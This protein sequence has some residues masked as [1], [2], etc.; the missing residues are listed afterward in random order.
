MSNHF[1]QQ[2]NQGHVSCANCVYSQKAER[3]K[4]WQ[5]RRYPPVL[6]SNS[7]MLGWKFPPVS[8]DYWCGEFV[9]FEDHN[10]AD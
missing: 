3:T 5:C 4:D 2:K 8:K 6:V 1:V 9:F 10:N 7:T